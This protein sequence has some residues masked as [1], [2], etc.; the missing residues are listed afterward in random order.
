MF[1]WWHRWRHESEF[2]WVAF[3]QVHHSPA[4]LE[5]LTSFYKAPYEIAADSIL[6]ALCHYTILGLDER[7]MAY[8]AAYSC[9]AEFIYHMN[10][11]SPHFIGEPNENRV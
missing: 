11:R 2:L 6:V 1:Y 9:Y 3:H 8:T 4:R 7:A 5:I 10:I